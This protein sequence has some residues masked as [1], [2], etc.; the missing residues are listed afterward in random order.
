[1]QHLL[2]T[3]TAR[4]YCLHLLP[5]F[6]ARSVF[7]LSASNG[8]PSSKSAAH[9][10]HLLMLFLRTV[11]FSQSWNVWK[12]VRV[13]DLCIQSSNQ[14]INQSINQSLKICIAP[15]QDPYSEA[16]SVKYD[17]MIIKL[18]DL[19]SIKWMDG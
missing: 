2:P 9:S 10:T 1:M 17:W 11:L 15:L 14:S 3:I 6:T 8:H 5:A 7:G 12:S 16:S 13:L 19:C 4:I 18:T